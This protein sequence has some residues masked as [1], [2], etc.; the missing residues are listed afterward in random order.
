MHD[1]EAKRAVS[2]NAAAIPQAIKELHDEVGNTA[3]LASEL[4]ARLNAILAPT[5]PRQKVTN[6]PHP[7]RPSQANVRGNINEAQVRLIQ[8]NSLLRDIIQRLEL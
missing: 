6:E 1:T 2:D 4:E 8:S 7:D 3:S 5:E